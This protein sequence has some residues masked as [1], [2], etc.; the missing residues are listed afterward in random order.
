MPII[1]PAFSPST[2][3][4]CNTSACVFVHNSATWMFGGQHAGAFELIARRP[5]QVEVELACGA[6]LEPP[7][8]DRQVVSGVA[9]CRGKHSPTT[10]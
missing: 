10:S 3:Y 4:E 1:R 6:R 9:E 2:R 5:P 8:E 7:V